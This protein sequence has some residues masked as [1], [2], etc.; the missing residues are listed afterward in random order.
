M[1]KT[2]S[3]RVAEIGVTRGEAEEKKIEG[4]TEDKTTCENEAPRKGIEVQVKGKIKMMER[5]V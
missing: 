4:V 1:W 5:D 3:N 2:I